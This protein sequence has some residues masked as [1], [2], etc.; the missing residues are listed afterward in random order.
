MQQIIFFFIRNKNFLLFAI[1]FVISLGFTLQTH[2]FHNGKFVSSAN[3]FSGSIYSFR[4]D[5]TNYFD[6]KTTNE[7]LVEENIRLRRLLEGYK[8]NFTMPSVDTTK[9]PSKYL[10]FASRVINNNYS[11]TKNNLTINN[12][13]SDGLEIDMGV[14]TTKGVVGII[15]S[16]SKNYATVQSILNTNSQLNA[17]LKNSNHFGTLT[18]DTKDPNVVQLIEIPRQATLVVGDTIITGGKSTIFPSGILIGSIEKFK[19]GKD[20]S[21]D[22]DVRL[23]NDMTDLNYVYII[24]NQD[25]AEILKLEKEMNDAEQ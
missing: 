9:I 2:T 22:I 25:A 10:F 3:F 5:I 11:R 20:D 21:Y 13:S 17:K 12:G 16:T 4:S 24:E 7:K 1:L 18:W 6:L 23:F 14:I 15:N 8:E 19:L